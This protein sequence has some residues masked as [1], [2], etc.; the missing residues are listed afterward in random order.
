M[1]T[2]EPR[3]SGDQ[4]ALPSPDWT[5]AKFTA[6]TLALALVLGSGWVGAVVAINPWS[7]F[8]GQALEPLVPNQYETK[9]TLWQAR[10]PLPQ[11]LLLGSSRGQG[12]HPV[13][14]AAAGF[15]N[16][17]NYAVGGAELDD[18]LAILRYTL[19]SAQG[20]NLSHLILALDLFQLRLG[21][22]SSLRLHNVPELDARHDEPAQFTD[23]LSVALY[24]AVTPT[25]HRDM[26]RS[27]VLT[28]K[29]HPESG[30]AFDPD[31]GPVAER[32]AWDEGT[33]QTGNPRKVSDLLPSHVEYFRYFRNL[34]PDG[35]ARLADI[36]DTATGANL[37]VTVLLTPMHPDLLTRLHQVTP[38]ERLHAETIGLLDQACTRYPGLR[39][40]D[41]TDVVALGGAPEDFDDSVHVVGKT[42]LLLLQAAADP[43]MDRCASQ[44]P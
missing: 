31:G 16:G 35:R 11:T 21:P 7:E 39:V 12:Y 34:D 37:S 1:S 26:L 13:M 28:V 14:M 29:G 27:V 20:A 22:S 25:Y 18:E 33:F 17:F 2:P 24:D 6:S 19:D 44:G 41:A 9:T 36:L 40:V 23:Y 15:P 38:R 43:A 4:A 5:V 8:P 30:I 32:I 3:H 10:D 42:N